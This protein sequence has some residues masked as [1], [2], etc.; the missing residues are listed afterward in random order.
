MFFP[1]AIFHFFCSIYPLKSH[2]LIFYITFEKKLIIMNNEKFQFEKG[3]NYGIFH[4]TTP[5]HRDETILIP[6]PCFIHC[7]KG[8]AKVIYN[9]NTYTIEENT[10]FCVFANTTIK[11][12]EESDDFNASIVVFSNDVIIDSTIGF[13][14]EYLASIFSSPCKQ[15]KDLTL[16]R[17]FSNLFDTLDTYNDIEKTFERST[18]FVYGIIRCTLISLAELSN[19]ETEKKSF[20]GNGFSTT[21]NYFRDFLKLLSVHCK[22]QHNVAFY[23][24]KLCIT[25]KYLNEICRKKTKKTAKEV[26][27]R[28][29]IAQIKNALMISG[30]SVQ[31]IAYEFN[32]C[33][34]SSF[35]KYFKKSVGM[36]P[37][38]FR[39]KFNDNPEEI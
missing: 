17:L 22:T 37:M 13:K 34:Q 4:I 38:A 32:F 15:I 7:S 1:L 39:N 31:R 27:T 11:S 5:T 14:T 30:T 3:K 12:I 33:D 19:Y 2:L 26:I 21:D 28:A 23:A 24:D 8:Y 36:A 29:V 25:P 9:T 6:Y 35:G 10:I 18:D 20:Y 16:K